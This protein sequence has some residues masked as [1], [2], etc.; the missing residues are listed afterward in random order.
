[1][2][3]VFHFVSLHLINMKV[4]QST[5]SCFM[6]RLVLTAV[7]AFPA[8]WSGI[9]QDTGVPPWQVIGPGGGGGVLKPTI[10]PLDENF[11]ITHCD[12]TALY[13]SHNGGSA[14]KMK[15]LYNVPEDI[16]FDPFDA[17]TVYVATK[18]FLY[19]EDRGS[20]ISMLLQSVDKGETWRIV[21]PEV[22][23]ARK[24]ERIQSTTLLP[25]DLIPGALN[26]TIQKVKVDPEDNHR[27]YL[28][29]TPLVDYMARSDKQDTARAML[30]RSDDRGNSWK[31]IAYLPGTRILGI[32]PD[33]STQ[34]VLVCTDQVCIRIDETTGLKQEIPLP[35]KNV[36]AVEGGA[37]KSETLL[38]LQSEIRIVNGKMQGGMYTSNDFGATWISANPGLPEKTA[39]GSVPEFRQGL[40]VC[41]NS[42]Q[43]AYISF[44]NPEINT[45]GKTEIIYSIYKTSNAGKTWRPVMLS[46]TPGGYITGNFAGSWMEESFDPGWGGSPIDLG[47]APGNPDV[48]YAGDNGRGYKTT[49]GGKTW[50]QVYSHNNPD[51]SYSGTGLHVT[52]CYGIHF[53]PFDKNHFFVCYTD[54]GLFHTFDGGK[55]WFHSLDGVPRDW[56][57]TCY[58]VAFDPDVPGKVWSVWANAH[59]LPRAK[60]FGPAG[61]GFF[62]GGVA[63]STDGGKSWN[64]Q[65]SGIP[66]N[67]VCT[68]ILIDPSSPP[69]SRVLY[70]SVFG[71]G[72]YVSQ[73]DGRTWKEANQGLGNNLF[74]WELRHA[75]G[76]VY[77]LFTRGS[78]KGR[79]VHG[80][81][82]YSDN[83]AVSWQALTLPE[84]VNG[85]HDLLID[86]RNPAHLYVSCWPYNVKGTDRFGGVIR[87][88]NG[89]ITWQTI[90]DERV[91]V[92]SAGMAADSSLIYIN[93]FQNAAYRSTDAG[94]N[95]QRIE[96]YRFKWGQKAIPDV[97]HP[98]MLYLTTYGGSV[99]YGPDAGIPDAADDITNM[100]ENWW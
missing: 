76:R 57:N 14:W 34:R 94:S 39:P 70:A 98:G 99:F 67:S 1:M 32:F 26:G 86:S 88:K 28:G 71:R 11:V 22:S 24:A 62:Q 64:A 85:P 12:M 20:G 6:E 25:S 80:A 35:A 83:Q 2:V 92:N 79:P 91:R 100:P 59:D 5:L 81:I 37:D 9:A 19:S 43:T 73:N 60:M 55:S 69:Q 18:G 95:W 61:F 15:N 17:G 49:D 48:C 65:N 21:Y 13:V 30:V 40:A 97:H 82:Y 29:M 31:V 58:Q 52:T 53:D 50:T 93:T 23:K 51:G 44:D 27:I 10:S 96:G 36:I 47:V 68:N 33:H 3:I 84:G 38:Y 54:I 4:F 8:T 77:A 7:F 89:G 42:P 16:E 66:A 45:E 74:A 63:V 75:S 46:S 78:E 87:S 90:F 72:I 41:A 56:Q